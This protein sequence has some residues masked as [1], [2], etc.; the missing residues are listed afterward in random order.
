MVLRNVLVV[1][2]P[3][4]QT[5]LKQLPDFSNDNGILCLKVLKVIDSKELL[6]EKLSNVLVGP[7]TLNRLLVVTHLWKLPLVE[8]HQIFWTLKHLTLLN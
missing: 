8:G 4:G 2:E 3:H 5:E 1:Q 7:E 6:S